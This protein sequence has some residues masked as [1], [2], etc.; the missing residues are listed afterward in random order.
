M[1]P[2]HDGSRSTLRLVT[3]AVI[4]LVLL[5]EEE[6]H[7]MLFAINWLVVSNSLCLLRN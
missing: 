2:M 4:L 1:R 3:M 5:I 7:V 6:P